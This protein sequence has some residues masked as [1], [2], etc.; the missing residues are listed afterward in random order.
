MFGVITIALLL[1]TSRQF[2]GNHGGAAN[3]IAA[4]VLSVF[5]L[6]D[7]F[8]PLPAAAQETNSYQDS[9]KN[10]NDLPAIKD[11]QNESPVVSGSLELK[12]IK[13][14]ITIQKVKKRFYL[15]LI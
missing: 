3:W 4:F 6:I 12:L 15:A 14:V 9:I 13:Y 2:P 7:A 8:A 11:K 1:W 10:L 5:P